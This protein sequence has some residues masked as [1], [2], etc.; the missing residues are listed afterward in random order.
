MKFSTKLFYCFISLGVMSTLLALFIIN[1]EAS[2][3]IFNENKNKILSLVI[4]SEQ[5]IN[6]T[7]LEEVIKSDGNTN[8]PA[9]QQ[10][11]TTVFG[12]RDFNRRQDT[13]LFSVFILKKDPAT[14]DYYFIIDTNK[15]PYGYRYPKHMEDPLK[16]KERQSSSHIYSTEWGNKLVGYAPIYGK[17]GEVLAILAMEV[18]SKEIYSELEKLMLYGL[19]AFA[20]S[21]FVA[22]F[23]AFFLS[24]LVSS[25]LTVLSKTVKSIGKGD[26]SHAQPLNTKDE[27]NDLSIAINNM[28]KG[29]T[30]RERLK[31]GFARYVSHHA[32]ED[33]LR[34]DKPVTLTGE[35]KKTTI[36]F[37]DIKGFTSMSE[38]LPPEEVLRI[39]NEYYAKMI[40]VVFKY[41]GT[42]DKFIGDG[43]MVEFGVPLED[44]LQE[45]HSLLCAIYMHLE[46]QKL[47]DKWEKEGQN[48][49][50]MGIGIHSGLAVLGNIG[51]ERRMEYTAIGDTVNV[52]SRLERITKSE[53]KE[54][55]VS[56]SVYEKTK[57]YFDFE[58]LKELPL[59]GRKGMI[60]AYSVDPF[61]E[62][63]VKLIE[64][65]KN[66]SDSSDQSDH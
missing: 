46:L 15:H 34:Q 28:A 50:E 36:L 13:F 20:I 64:A 39:L 23:F 58:D 12:I 6:K 4:N 1:G 59:K 62:K 29:L 27:F 21:I 26:F 54:I 47:S 65:K 35:R 16:N 55:I 2:R 3:L 7:V 25:S 14:K 48:R 56:D 52:A 51:S 18:S 41:G 61:L 17:K 43:M 45:Y 8:T 57:E 60:Q 44:N 42:L 66:P 10:L 31:E 22:I 32:M 24:K 33:L 63:H 37:S 49:L 40:E 53:N 30:E 5:F 38:N 11:K 9:Y 19:I